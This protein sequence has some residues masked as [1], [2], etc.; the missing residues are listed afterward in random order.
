M[1]FGS[2]LINSFLSVPV[3]ALLIYE[4][5]KEHMIYSSSSNK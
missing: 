5:V 1:N 3:K 2:F 4:R